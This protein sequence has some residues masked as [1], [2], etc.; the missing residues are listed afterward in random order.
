MNKSI[1]KGD[2]LTAETW[3]DFV[4]R[5]HHDCVGEGVDRHYTSC[6]LFTVEQRKID[7]GIDQDCTTDRLIYCDDSEWANPAAYLAECDEDQVANLDKLAQIEGFPSFAA[8]NDY[9]QWDILENLDNHGVTGWVE[10]WEYVNAHLTRD[11]ADAFIARK[12]HDYPKGMRVYVESQ[13]YAW[14]FNTIKEAIL[15]GKLIYKD[16]EVKA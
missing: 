11:A 16:D 1:A 3:V 2:P 6:A 9:V 13:Y 14:E 5:L 15:A 4:A 12:K 8:A 7:T 10:R